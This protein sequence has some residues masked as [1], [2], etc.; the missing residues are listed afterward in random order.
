MILQS[1]C[2]LVY[3]IEALIPNTLVKVKEAKTAIQPERQECSE[4]PSVIAPRHH[5]GPDG[6]PVRIRLL[7]RLPASLRLSRLQSRLIASYTSLKPS[8]SAPI[9]QHAIVTCR[10]R[11]PNLFSHI[12]PE[13]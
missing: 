13:K 10:G 6:R 4:L 1:W 5:A 2:D 11:S 12:S 3:I 8:H 7:R 9:L